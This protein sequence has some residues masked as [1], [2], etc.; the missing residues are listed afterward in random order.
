MENIEK[1]MINIIS[2]RID[3]TEPLMNALN[4]PEGTALNGKSGEVTTEHTEVF[5]EGELIRRDGRVILRYEENE[6]S[7]ME[8]AVTE[9]SYPEDNPGFV[10]MERG[11]AFLTSFVFENGK[12][13]ICVYNT[14]IMA[15]E[16][17]IATKEVINRLDSEGYI[18]LDYVLELRGAGA[19]RNKIRI[20]VKPLKA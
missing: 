8:G 4:E 14:P 5:S 3:N 18:F 13:H 9:I 19:E 2:D 16:I 17:C 20:S 12:R 15:F 11:G 7:G 6:G 1:V 10:T